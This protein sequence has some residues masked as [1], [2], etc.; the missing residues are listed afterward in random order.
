VRLA[1]QLL[2][3]SSMLSP[4]VQK[5]TMLC[6]VSLACLHLH[7]TDLIVQRE[8][9]LTL[10][11]DFVIICGCGGAGTGVATRTATA[12]FII[13]LQA[14]LPAETL[15][16]PAGAWC[17]K[18]QSTATASCDRFHVHVSLSRCWIIT[19][20]SLERPQWYRLGGFRRQ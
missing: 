16:K 1:D 13:T 19:N 6:E 2:A 10:I 17:F 9:L 7:D 3:Q 5:A 8:S 15:Q 11:R 12:R 18:L 4:P 14:R 20:D